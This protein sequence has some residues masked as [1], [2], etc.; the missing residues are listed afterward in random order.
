MPIRR[1]SRFGLLLCAATGLAAL[2]I[3]PGADY[4]GREHASE[5]IAADLA[6]IR[7]DL[8]RLHQLEVDIEQ[9]LLAAEPAITITLVDTGP[10][11]LRAVLADLEETLGHVVVA[12]AEKVTICT[13]ETALRRHGID[14]KFDFKLLGTG[15]VIPDFEGPDLTTDR[16]YGG[17]GF[18][19]FGGGDGRGAPDVD[20]S[21]EVDALSAEAFGVLTAGIDGLGFLRYR[22]LPSLVDDLENRLIA[23]TRPHRRRA[24]ARLTACLLPADADLHTGLVAVADLPELADATELRTLV[25]RGRIGQRVVAGDLA[26][27][28]QCLGTMVEEGGLTDPVFAVANHGCVADVRILAD[29]DGCVFVYELDWKRLL[30]MERTELRLPGALVPAEFTLEG[31]GTVTGS[32]KPGKEDADPAELSGDLE[33]E[34]TGALVPASRRMAASIELDLPRWW[35]WRTGGLVGL[36]EATA[37]VL[38]DEFDAERN[39]VMIL[40]VLP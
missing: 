3:D 7:F 33:Q 36:D 24:G 26:Q 31:A 39:A 13:R 25:L 6:G 9:D 16:N 20:P 30:D 40:E 23:L 15:S 17:G 4:L 2:E 29:G 5:W 34:L 37:L 10:R 18:D 12:G 11:P 21:L 28:T 38:V 19:I 22:T 35:H 14:V 8:K 27:C 1:L 32:V